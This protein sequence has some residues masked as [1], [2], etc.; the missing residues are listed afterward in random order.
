MEYWSIEKADFTAI[1]ITPSIHYS[2]SPNLIDNKISQQK[3][4]CFD[5]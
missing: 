5:L 4:P 3:L 2:V 1:A